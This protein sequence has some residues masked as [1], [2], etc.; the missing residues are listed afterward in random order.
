MAD[1]VGEEGKLCHL[2][3]EIWSMHEKLENSAEPSNSDAVQVFKTT[4]LGA[5]GKM[6]MCGC[7]DIVSGYHICAVYYMTSVMLCYD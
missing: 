7:A 1:N 6:R 2:F 3:D 5:G 4:M